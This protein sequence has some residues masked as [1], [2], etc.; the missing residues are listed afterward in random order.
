M[1]DTGVVKKS[2]YM[3]FEKWW[4][5]PPPEVKKPRSL[6]SAASLAYLG[7]CIY[8]VRIRPCEHRYRSVLVV[9]LKLAFCRKIWFFLFLYTALC[10]EA[11]LL[12]TSEH[13]W[14]QQT[15]DGCC[16][17]W[18]TGMGLP[19]LFIGQNSTFIGNYMTW[20]QN[21]FCDLL[22]LGICIVGYW[23]FYMLFHLQYCGYI[24]R[25]PGFQKVFI[26]FVVF[27]FSFLHISSSV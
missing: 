24:V 13:Q 1:V 4:L 16:E 21:K 23:C 18:V 26:P 12:S 22:M 2:T 9:K 19:I 7:D 17:V 10:S 25:L 14:V 20:C 5:P 15:C 3:G 6:Y 27:Q 11:L 8:E